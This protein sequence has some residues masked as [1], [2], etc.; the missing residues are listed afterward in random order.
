M[1]APR[2]YADELQERAT[3]KAVDARLDPATRSGNVPPRGRAAG[4]PS[5]D[6]AELGPAG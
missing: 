3:W 4:D 5:G 1:A 6:V 2:K